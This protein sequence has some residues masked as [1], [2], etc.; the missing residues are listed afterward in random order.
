MKRMLLPLFLL[1]VLVSSCAKK[2]SA[3]QEAYT[4]PL[5]D[6]YLSDPFIFAD[7]RDHTYY[8][9][10]SGGNGR[11]MARASK[12]LRNWTDRFVVCQFPADHWAGPKAPTWAAEVHQ[13]QGKYYLFTTSDD[14]KPM[15]KNIRG[16]DYPHRATQIYVAN[17]PRGP[18]EDF[19]NNTPHTPADW[20]C[21]DGTLWV[22]NGVPYLVFCHEW[23]Q[24]MDGTME[25]V[26][27]P[28]NLGVPTA[29]PITLF[30]GSD[31]PFIEEAQPDPQK[32]YVTD[33][34]Y[35]FKTQTGRLGMLWST[36]KDG[37]YVLMAAY[38]QFDRIH[39]PWVQD[40][41]LL[42]ENGGHGMLFRTFD[43]TLMLSL[44]Y[45]ESNNERPRR[46]PMFMEVDDSGDRLAIKQNG[47]VMK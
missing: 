42:F 18:F 7:Q 9:Y 25:A 46:K 5:S 36:W 45:I 26:R 27:L 22:E 41:E 38:S 20:P 8:M 11:V 29:S 23:T 34:P 28:Q 31:A 10:G 15:G 30:R 33:G 4:V 40:K 35:V 1:V 43:G 44:H 2:S 13:Y 21:L 47:I 39:G 12:D 14:G 24:I 37:V 19:T 32:V 16:D 3:V 17:S 6:I